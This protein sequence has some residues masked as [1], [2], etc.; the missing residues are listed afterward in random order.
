ML[1]RLTQAC[2]LPFLFAVAIALDFKSGVRVPGYHERPTRISEC[3]KRLET[4]EVSLV[5]AGILI[6][7]VGFGLIQRF[8][9]P[10]CAAS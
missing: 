1:F 7:F 6:G 9:A 5:L 10:N 4:A 8:S 2:V 3:I